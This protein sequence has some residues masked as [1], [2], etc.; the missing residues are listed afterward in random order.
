MICL[1]YGRRKSSCIGTAEILPEETERVEVWQEEVL[2][3]W[4]AV[5]VPL[6]SSPFREVWQEEVLLHW[7]QSH[8]MLEV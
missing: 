2:L 1:K 3:H 8:H 5:A 7:N 4:N 6:T